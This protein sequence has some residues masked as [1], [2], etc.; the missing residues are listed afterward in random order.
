MRIRT[1]LIW[2]VVAAVALTV[3][4]GLSI[5][6]RYTAENTFIK[7]QA[8]A[9]TASRE[10]AGL[11]V[12]TQ[13]FAFAGNSRAAQQW[14]KRF[15]LINE[16]VA[17]SPLVL[18]VPSTAP[19]EIK[20]GLTIISELFTILQSIPAASSERLNKRRTQMVADQ[21]IAN[22]QSLSEDAYRWA[23]EVSAVHKATTQKFLAIFSAIS[24]GFALIILTI[25]DIV[26]RRVLHPVALL[27]RSATQI[28]QGNLSVRSNNV[29]PDEL[30]DL[31]REFDEMT[32]AIELR[33]A[34][35][36]Q[37][38]Q[39]L[40]DQ[41]EQ[42][43][44][45]LSSIGDA[46]ITTDT[47]GNVTYLNPI[48][49]A[50]TGWST[51]E[52]QGVRSST[53]FQIINE[54]TGEVA[55]DPIHSVLVHKKA[56]GLAE[57][58]TL[59]QRDGGRFAIEDT[60][61]PIKDSKGAILGV[62]LVFHDVSTKRKLAAEITHQASHDSLT[63]L[64]NRR[65]F[66][67]RL[68]ASIE[69]SKQNGL[70]HTLLYLDLDQF[71]IVNDTCGHVAGDELLRQLTALLELKLRKSDTLARLGGD[72]F[73]VLLQN[74]NTDPAYR[75]AEILRQAVSD[76]HFVWLDNAF[77]IGVSIGQITFSGAISLPEVLRMADAACYVAKDGG[78][79]RI[80]I[81]TPEDKEV[82]QRSGEM[83]WISRIQNALDEK[84]FVL[85]TQKILSL[86][87]DDD[88]DHCEILLRMKDENGKIIPPM[89]F[90]PAAERYGFMAQLDRWV[91]QTAFQAMSAQQGAGAGKL[92]CAIN[93]SGKSLSD[94]KFLAFVKDQFVL[95]DLSPLNVCF[96]ITE[97]AAIVNLSTAAAFMRELRTLGVRFALD[98][99]G[100][101]MSSFAY[102][103]YL[104]V[105]YLKIDGAFV[106]DMMHDEID[107]AM[108]ESINNIGHK[109]GIRTI[110][111]YVENDDIL[112]ALRRIGVDF[113]QGYGIEM[114]RPISLGQTL[115]L[116]VG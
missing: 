28:R 108:V 44:V 100:S 86:D 6:A 45:T 76:F 16:V 13:E 113:A 112:Q 59:L 15:E 110:A 24:F 63:G 69:S 27:E 90:I 40:L 97:T 53:V 94:D 39:S 98:D 42:L 116:N 80:H 92:T 83:G 21:L 36:A 3:A 67:R 29:V 84:R 115:A 55:E 10:A 5:F 57:H 19:A 89:A 31:A 1:Q 71:K 26:M 102:L 23:D 49:E 12:L 114:P 25:G 46:V 65:E 20:A 37:A 38:H 30:G 47:D 96:E 9:Q 106:K 7:L 56:A 58:T 60:A 91:I 87:S 82:A 104:P 51:V 14:W 2:S 62:V 105:D 4:M 61:A 77:P 11:I 18:K 35:I 48:A 93:L 68:G 99:F 41:K 111:E 33:D 8:R 72:E 73:G 22:V 101:G 50:M 70:Q 103:K 78:R 17:P 74:C 34:E 64:I 52:A 81:Y 75:V 66:E 79:N 85:Y 32:V 43:R 107:F 88:S 109:M 95:H 54:H